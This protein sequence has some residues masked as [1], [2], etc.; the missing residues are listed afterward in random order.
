MKILK[1]RLDILTSEA[2]YI[3]KRYKYD[4]V[5]PYL[6]QRRQALDFD[7]A[8]VIF[9]ELQKIKIVINVKHTVDEDDENWIGDVDKEKLRK[10]SK[11]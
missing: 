6:F 4:R 7:T 8:M 1:E 9:R 5:S 11:N 2:I 3:C 10:L